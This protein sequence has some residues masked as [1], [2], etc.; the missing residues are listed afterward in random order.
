MWALFG[1]YWGYSETSLRV[2]AHL[3][4]L[5]RNLRVDGAASQNA[6]GLGD[7]I[8]NNPSANI[9]TILTPTNLRSLQDPTSLI[10]ER[11]WPSPYPADAGNSFFDRP[12]PPT[13][14]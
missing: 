13:T 6:I 7:D 2:G 9:T 11:L 1:R 4:Q 3:N 8:Y 10:E 5:G 14:P 12:T